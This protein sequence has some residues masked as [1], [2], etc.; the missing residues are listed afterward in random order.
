VLLIVLAILVSLVTLAL[1]FSLLRALR[2]H[3]ARAPVTRLRHERRQAHPAARDAREAIALVGDAL[4]AT[5][6]PRAL[7]PLILEV[8]TEATGARG[9][10]M[11]HEGEEVGWFGEA[12]GRARPLTLDLASENSETDTKLLLYPHGRGFDAE[13]RKL[14]EWVAAQAGIALEN[15]R[16]H[17]EVRRQATTDELT[18]LVNRRRFIEALETELERAKMFDSPLS[19]VL[20]DL[21][22]FKRINDDYGHH[23]GDRALT[24]FGQLLRDQVRD[25]DVAARL[26]GEEFA[27]LLPQTTA[28]AAAIV[29][30]RMRD[31]LAASSIEVSEKAKVQLTASFG[32]A[33]SKPDQTTDELLRRADD[34]L[35]AAKRGGKNRYVI[36]TTPT[37]RKAS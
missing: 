17:E 10:Q 32:I 4:A 25:F 11:L 21:D 34:A 33:E 30:A 7:V 35:Y 36:D 13:T 24:A 19:V 26:G 37:S 27:I 1:L 5:H 14:A 3:E 12:G 23:A 16:L 20:A 6:N 22:D 31:A 29:A 15:A 2:T 9:A 8:V 18:N 28:A